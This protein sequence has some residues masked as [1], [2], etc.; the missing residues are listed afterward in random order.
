MIDAIEILLADKPQVGAQ[1]L[2]SFHRENPDFLPRIVAEFRLLKRRGRKKEGAKA[3]IHFLRWEHDWQRIDQFEINDHLS[4]LAMRLCTLLWPDISGMARFSQCG[5]DDILGTR[6]VRRPKGNGRV[7][8]P[9]KRTLNGRGAFLAVRT[10]GV[11][12]VRPIQLDR[13]VFPPPVPFLDRP[14]TFHHP[15]TETEGASIAAQLREIVANAPNPR[16]RLLLDWSAHF[17]AQPEI[18]AFIRNTLRNRRPNR[19]SANSLLEYGRR[20]VRHAAE[21]HKRFTLPNVLCGLYSRALVLMDP[22]FNGL[23]ELRDG[24][25]GLSNRIL[26]CTLAPKPINSEPYRRLLRGSVTI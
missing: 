13:I 19:F 10:D 12:W 16:H 1:K 25:S 20:S 4:S 18:L 26:G 7:L 9:T 6:I 23:C 22:Q 3:V 14:A 11:G 8:Y 2:L 15:I 5:A 17:E 24:N 21:S